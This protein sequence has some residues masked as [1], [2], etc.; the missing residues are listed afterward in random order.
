MTDGVVT[1]VIVFTQ[2]DL[3]AFLQWRTVIDQIDAYK[4]RV[5]A[6]NADLVGIGY[7]P[8]VPSPFLSTSSS[9]SPQN[10]TQ[11]GNGA[12]SIIVSN[13]A[14]SS[15]TS[16][17]VTVTESAPFGL[18]VTSMTG[19]GW[20]CNPPPPG[21]G[22]PVAPNSCFRDDPLAP[23]ANYPLILIAVSVAA[24]APATVS[25][26]VT[27]SGG[28]SSSNSTL[29]TTTVNPAR[30]GGRFAAPLG[31]SGAAATPT[32]ASPPPTPFATAL[33]A[34]PTLVSL[35][36]FL[37]TAFAVNE[38][39]SP[40]QGTMT[41]APLI[42]SVA[43]QL[44]AWNYSVYVPSAYVPSLIGLQSFRSLRIWVKLAELEDSRELLATHIAE[45]NG[46]L[47]QAY[48]VTQNPSKY[49]AL[50]LNEALLKSGKLQSALTYAQAVAAT[51]D[52]FEASIFGAQIVI[53]SQISTQSTGGAT[54]PAPASST[55]AATP[56][57]ASTIAASTST[58]TAS[59]PSQLS[60]AAALPAST[61]S[62]TSI[63]STGI[64]LTQLI[65]AELL[66]AEIYGTAAAPAN[67][68]SA[69]GVFMLAL[70]SLESGGSQLVKG[71][72]FIGTRY[73]FS[74]GAAA[75]FSLYGL[76]GQLSCSGT[77]HG[78]RGFIREKDVQTALYDRIL[79]PAISDYGCGGAPAATTISIG[80][81]VASVTAALGPPNS[82]RRGGTQ[83]DYRNLHKRILF[84][85]GLVVAIMDK[86]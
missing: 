25:N 5:D 1:K 52:T 29:D 23:G 47:A 7:V 12:Y 66:A 86:F 24:G 49:S 70:H 81:T 77:V 73:Y 41:D 40:S 6:I 2:S 55:A 37:A 39:L 64:N 59:A 58:N 33:S 54:S 83:Y 69:P 26:V 80:M 17:R 9:H 19:S 72:T 84:S 27:V 60:S 79:V 85:S 22:D 30:G 34:I 14:S 28:S 53:P 11:G 57:A 46:M 56:A 67:P 44:R 78:Y 68:A 50:D 15:T 21:P 31:S 42:N 45:R 18:T 75:D 43:A 63:P 8:A 82:I 32:P 10:F 20:R 16:G 38:T 35:A 51:V 76:G 13:G 36:Q 48:F 3:T 4:Q 71:N 65:S 62:T 61:T 74:G